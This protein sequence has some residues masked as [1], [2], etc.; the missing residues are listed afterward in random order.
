MRVNIPPAS[1]THFC[2]CL[3]SCSAFGF[4]PLW[5]VKWNSGLCIA[6]FHSKGKCCTLWRRELGL[7]A[8]TSKR[9]V[10]STTKVRFPQKDEN[11]LNITATVRRLLTMHRRWKSR[12]SRYGCC[13]VWQTYCLLFRAPRP[14]I[15]TQVLLCI[16]EFL[17][18]NV[19][20]LGQI[21]ARHASLF[22]THLS[23]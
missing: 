2:Q 18:A 6:I 3:P 15:L 7:I 12:L 13:F 1:Y 8:C 16:S 20:I 17:K 14:A 10:R 21:R 4:C 9:N 11:I 22:A 23:S 5:S 19:A